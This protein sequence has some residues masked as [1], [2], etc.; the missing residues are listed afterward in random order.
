MTLQTLTF[1]GRLPGVACSPAL[2]PVEQPI[3]GDVAA[4]VGFAERGPV[5]VPVAVIDIASFNA[6]FG[7]DFVL[8]ID[9]GRPVYAQLPA[10]VKAFFDNGG[11]RCYAVRVAGR[12]PTVS[13][14]EV[15]GLE[16]WQ[17]GSPA[18]DY[19]V[20]EAA[21]PGRWSVDT[22]VSVSHVARP[23][24]A[25]GVYQR[26]SNDPGQLTLDP[27]AA[28]S[29]QPGD[30]LDL[31][32]GPYG[33][34]LYV[35]ASSVTGG[36]VLTDRELTYGT[37]SE[38]QPTNITQPLPELLPG[39]PSVMPVESVSLL[40]MDLVVQRLQ[41][42]QLQLVER[43][44]DLAYAS[45]ASVLQPAEHFEPDL[46][47]SM[48]LR[49]DVGTEVAAETGLIVPAPP[50][51]RNSTLQEGDDDLDT[52]D[53]QI[54][55]VDERL[56]NDTVFSLLSNSDTLTSLAA[57]PAKLRGMHALL[58][59]GEVA[60]VA[61][62]D[63]TNRGW[64]R[65]PSPPADPDPEE[66]PPPPPPDWS[67]FR[68]CEVA[69]VPHP[70]PPA[71]DPVVTSTPARVQ[72]DPITAYDDA[73]LLSVQQALVIMCAARADLVGLLSVPQ[74]Y[75]AAAVLDWHDQ[76][77]SASAVADSA[78]SSVRPLSYAAYWHPWLTMPEPIGVTAATGAGQVA[79]RQVP[80]DGPVAGMIAARELDRGIWIAPAAVALRGPVG[81]E[82]KLT[83]AETVR[84]FDAHAN[85]IRQRPGGFA[86]IA[87]HSLASDQL[88]QLSIRRL[89]ILVRKIAVR[90]GERY[91]FEINNERFRQLVQRRFERIL[92]DLT[93]RGA[94]HAFQVLTDGGVNSADDV[95]NGR[96]I[97]ALQV[98]P[99]SP[100][101]FVT[102][103][104][105]R[106]GEGLLEVWEG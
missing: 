101:E 37:A 30:L 46:S 16:I 13:R 49:A 105:L 40:R 1:H 32:L 24:A 103:T 47:R 93:G 2:P 11:V 92:G 66:P 104:L 23:L 38:G 7:G 62:P 26:A 99:S 35:R 9:S 41:D 63:V 6:I 28:A 84:L 100:V 65:L 75:D 81:L 59:V 102:V 39:L 3:R 33:M 68:C 8:A 106:S 36:V 73:P 27:R 95:E 50:S 71:P 53:P 10:A 86:A 70:R 45:S 91:T 87:A 74:H 89:L 48:N 34:T 5:D 61:L 18:R 67:D 43:F 85:V 44:N 14:W 25:V 57:Q 54:S 51:E 78:T 21:W 90:E 76:L 82:P 83:E 4:F 72:L 77:T 19:V 55:Y 42:G 69:E 98:A 60:M 94:F 56:A 29:I 12:H 20:V 17:P 15:P 22:Q 97:V 96:L 88:L 31:L 58:G 80:P 64:S 52:F 79:L